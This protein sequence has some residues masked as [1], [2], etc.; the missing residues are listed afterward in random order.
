[1]S[2]NEPDDFVIRTYIAID[3]DSGDTFGI[4]EFQGRTLRFGTIINDSLKGFET[5]EE[6]EAFQK[7]VGGGGHIVPLTLRPNLA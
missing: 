2:N 6:A 5:R 1:M 4:A 7:S 3:P